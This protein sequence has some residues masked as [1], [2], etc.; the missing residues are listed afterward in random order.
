MTRI[1]VVEDDPSIRM[2]LEDTLTAKGYQVEVVGKGA[3][4]AER[5]LSG[6]YDLVVLDVMLPD[7]DG[8]EVCRRI[9]EMPDSKGVPIVYL[10]ALYHDAEHRVLGLE[11]GADAYLK[12]PVEPREL[13]ATVH[14]LLRSRAVEAAVRESERRFRTLVETTSQVIWTTTVEGRMEGDQPSWEAFSGQTPA[15]H[16][17]DGWMEA[18]HP[19]DRAR[20]RAEWATAVAARRPLQTELRLRRHDGQYREMWMRTAPVLNS[21]GTVREWVGAC[22]DVSERRVIEHER[23]HA[24]AAAEQARADAEEASRAKSGFLANMSHEIRTPINAIIGYTDLLQL[25]VAGELTDA[26]RGHLDRVRMSSRHLLTLIEDILDLAKIESGQMAVVDAPGVISQVVD[27]ALA[28]VIPQAREKGLHIDNQ[29]AGETTGYQGDE[30]RVRQILVNLLS[31]AVKFT[32]P[33]G[34]VTVHAGTAEPPAG[35]EMRC[36]GQC[37][38]IRV[39]DTGPGISANQLDAVFEPFVQGESGHTRTKGGTGLGLAISR[40]LARLMGGDV[41]VVSQIDRGSSFTI[42]LPRAEL[43]GATA[44]PPAATA[45]GV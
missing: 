44:E 24:L 9:R 42:W 3:E 41:T 13:V 40:H 25:G 20:V 6:R 1:L 23:D 26:Q 33:G 18:V 8:F 15:Q 35:S 7:I 32:Q 29:A 4:G 5:A 36:A 45:A 43:P 11:V 22:Q 30:D 14:A 16:A 37:A 31:N 2:G 27:A 19:E 10:S 38:F 12:Q 39:E 34:T 21:D 17:G 28:L